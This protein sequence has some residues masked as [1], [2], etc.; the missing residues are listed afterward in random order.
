MGR[1]GTFC[2]IGAWIKRQTRMSAIAAVSPL[3]NGGGLGSP[4]KEDTRW[5]YVRDGD[6]DVSLLVYTL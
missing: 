5:G 4:T 1:G 6:D 2:F 3:A